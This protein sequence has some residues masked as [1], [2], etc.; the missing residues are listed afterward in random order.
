MS[1]R[2]TAINTFLLQDSRVSVSIPWKLFFNKKCSAPNQLG[3]SPSKSK[4]ILFNVGGQTG[5]DCLL[6]WPTVW[7][8][9]DRRGNKP[10]T[11]RSESAALTTAPQNSAQQL[12]DSSSPIHTLLFQDGR[13][14]VSVPLQFS[15][16]FSVTR[17]PLRQVLQQLRSLLL[18]K[19]REKRK[20]Q[21]N[22]TLVW[23][24][25]SVKL[26][27]HCLLPCCKIHLG[28]NDRSKNWCNCVL[29]HKNSEKT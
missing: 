13:V 3:H 11:F 10:A 16:Q 25:Y 18:Q 28:F 1:L 17:P 2:S 24:L 6:T 26:R 5:K 27:N 15:A 8:A 23:W 7:N 12:Y 9:A 29:P 4:G 19:E 14:T 21:M 20:E 22:E